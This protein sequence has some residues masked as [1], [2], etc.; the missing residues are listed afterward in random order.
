MTDLRAGICLATLTA[1]LSALAAPAFADD[2]P[3]EAAAASPATQSPATQPAQSSKIDEIVV[4]AQRR[5]ESVLDVPLAIQASTAL[6]LQNAGVSQIT[7][8]QFITPGYSVDDSNGYTQIFIRGIGNAIFVGADPS[9]ATFIDDVPRIYGSMVN[10]FVDV[11]RVEVLKGAQGG[12]YGRNATGG[13][14]NII[15]RQPSTEQISADVKLD[16]GSHNT[17]DAQA[18]VN[19]PINTV[20]AVSFGGERRY[21][22]PYIKNL[23]PTNPYSAANFPTGSFLG[24]P[25][26]TAAFFNSGV[27]NVGVSNQNFWAVN[28]KILFK[29]SENFK[30]TFAG[31][32]SLKNDSQGNGQFEVTP[33]YEQAVLQA[34]FAAFGI[35]AS[36]PPGF[37]VGNTPKFT[38]AAGTPGYVYLKDYGGSATA[39]LNLPGVDLTSI[40]AYR[41]QHTSFV[42][43][44]GASSVPLTSALVDNFKHYFYQELR[45][46]SSFSGPFQFIAGGSYLHDSFLGTT[47]VTVLDP[48]FT[49]EVAHAKDV[50]KNWSVYAQ[51]SYEIVSNLT[52]TA[53]G[54]YVHEKNTADFL[55][56]GNTL[57]S[58]EK[59]FLPAAT[60][61]YKI[62]GGGT[63]YAR[64]A[65]GFKAGGVNPVA[66]VA[67]FQGH[68]TSGSVFQGESVD[69]FEGGYKG[70]LFDHRV[71]LTADVFYNNYKNLQTAA[72]VN[73]AFA[74]TVIEAIIN[75]GSART[76]GVEG[77]VSWRVVRPLTV[78]LG[79][80]YLNA[81]YKTFSHVGD[82][83]LSAF[84]YSGTQMPNA[85]TFQGNATVNLDQPITDHLNLTGNV[86]VSRT[87]SILWQVSGNPGI[88]PAAQWPG[89]WLTNA[90]IG[91]KTSDSRYSLAVY[92]NNLFNAAYTT[93]GNSNAGNSTLYTWGNPRIIGVELTMHM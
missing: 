46:V 22:D 89:Y 54:R 93:Y 67:A 73:A 51:A 17:V 1:A 10:N 20:L 14:V 45:A 69:T 6:Q 19:I 8:L 40:T 38:V 62:D 12:L 31:D 33:A 47:N 78:S 68:L 91:I 9:V 13:V 36:L 7:D 61:S 44:L 41:K 34:T 92:A 37:V 58:T 21:S 90:R 57:S 26:Q 28:G 88:L 16:Y 24:T 66:D 49:S 50:V 64:W 80:G 18:Y 85:P 76:Y 81:K 5:Q 75:A 83:I 48:L 74:N 25:A 87:S 72:H 29:P 63:I 52:L 56:S 39:V 43:D 27:H 23:A 3:A 84:D 70:T 86:V 55:L 79:A 82:V 59:K 4:T 35:N 77:S 15:T 60:L 11:D 42:D 65:R 71:Q 2:Q 32:Y 53:S 30:I